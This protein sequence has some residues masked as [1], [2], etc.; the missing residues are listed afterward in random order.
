MANTFINNVIRVDT[1]AAFALNIRIRS[2]K[3]VGDESGTA[4]VR[5]KAASD[6]DILWNH[7]GDVIAHDAN[8]DIVAKDGVYVTVTN[9]AV[10]YL[11]LE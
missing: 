9:G 1:T 11:Y 5:A 2:I 10:V 6:G 7:T 3:Y 4:D 8:I